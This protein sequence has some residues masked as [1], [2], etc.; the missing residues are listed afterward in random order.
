V[1]DRADNTVCA[2]D[3]RTYIRGACVKLDQA[4]DLVAY[5]ASTHEVWV[6][7]PASSAIVIL[8]VTANPK[9]VGSVA[10]PGRPEGLAVNDAAGIVY[11]NLED[12]DQTLA[13]DLHKRTVT[14]TW[15]A[16]CGDGGPKGLLA[17]PDHP[18]VLVACEDHLQVIDPAK[19]GKILSTVDT[20]A[21]LDL[22]DYAPTQK[23]FYAAAG[24][25]SQLTIVKVD[26]K[27]ALSVVTTI[28]TASGA[29]NA[30]A[31][32]DGA[33]VLTNASLGGVLYVPAPDL[34]VPQPSGTP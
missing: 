25:A 19:K 7:T 13:I 16:K 8:D 31:A 2:V 29:R 20:G 28:P 11:T 24:R 32:A 3:V 18:F 27:G 4:P 6:T 1:G 33:A 12:K 26:A 10:V 23:W 30:V 5:V 14:A 34:S 21:G 9:V 17:D 22:F 15:A